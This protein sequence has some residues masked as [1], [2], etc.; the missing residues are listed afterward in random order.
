MCRYVDKVIQMVDGKITSI[1]GDRA[2]I[3]A[4]ANGQLAH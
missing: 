1:V 2:E 3:D 4:L